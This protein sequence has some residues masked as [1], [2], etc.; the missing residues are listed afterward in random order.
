MSLYISKNNENTGPFDD[1]SI[2][3]ALLNGSLSVN[4]L[5]CREGMTAWQPLGVLFPHIM[6]Y[7]PSVAAPAFKCPFCQ[8]TAQP[9]IRQKVS[10]AGWIWFIVLF[11][12]CIGTVFC[13]IGLLLKENYR[14]C[15]SCGITLG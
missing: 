8:S 7:A 6:T 9:L 3:N 10:T 2:E 11:G 13:W 14:V 4:D 1:T 15:R 5:G 12:S